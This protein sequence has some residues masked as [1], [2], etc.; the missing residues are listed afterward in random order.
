[1]QLDKFT[2]KSQEALQG[3]G[4]I[5]GTLGHQEIV[6]EHLFKIILEQKDGLL[7]PVIQKIGCD[8]SAVS[9][10]VEKL[11][12]KI[13]KVSGSGFGQVYASVRLTKILDQSLKE[14]D[15][16]RD[17]YVSLEHLVLAMLAEDNSAL[18]KMCAANSITRDAFL[19][20]L[21][22]IRGSQRVTDQNPEEKYQALEKYSANL[23]DLA[24]RGKLDPV[25]G[26]D[27]EVRRVIQVLSRRTKNNP[28]L[29][30][31]PGVGKTAIVE[32][33]A[34]RIVMGDI[35]ETL[36]NKEVVSLDLGALIAG[37]KYRG[38]FE[39][40][41]KAVLKEVKERQ[42]EIVLFIDEIHTLVGAGASEGAM[43]ASNMLKPALARGELHCVGATTLN[44]Y[45]TIEKDSALERRFQKV[46][47][48]EPSV[49]DSI[50][51]LRGI[52]E[53]YEVHHGVRIRDGATVAAVTL[54]KRYITDRFLP[55]KAIDLI[56]EAASHIRIE[57]DSM[58][59]E[60]DEV[61]RRRIK[62]EIEREALK[63]E[64]DEASKQRLAKL[65]A[66]LADLNEQLHAMKGHWQ[67]EHDVIQDIRKIKSDMEEAKIQEQ[68]AER[69]QDLSR[70]AE[71]RHGLLVELSHKLEE[72]NEKLVAIQADR[73]M[74]KEEV[75]AE[76]IAAVVAR[77]TGIPVDKLL[78]GE[79][80][81]LVGAEAQLAKRVIG[82]KRAISAVANAVRRARAGLQ[83]PNRPLGSFIFLGPTG[84]G[85]TELARALAEFLFDSEQAMVR[86]DM[87]E[88]MEKHS[89][90]RLIGAPP[91]YV[92]YEQGG[93]LTEAVRR[94][95][96]AVILFDE[97][98]KAHPDVFNVLL[99]ILDD[100]RMT[101]GQGRTVDFKN[102]ILIMTSNLG[103]QIIM[104]HGIDN[105]GR[106]ERELDDVLKQSFK[107]EFLNRVDDTITFHALT[108]VELSS[109]V[110]IQLEFLKSRMAA[111]GYSLELT[112]DAKEFIVDVG[113]DPL[114]GARPMKRAVQ[115]YLQDQLAM[116]ILAGH[117]VGKAT[118]V[119]DYK[120]GADALSFTVK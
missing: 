50:A 56:D 58:P 17:D 113:Y 5:A 120:R 48:L 83:D 92:G 82:Q 9:S 24:R 19:K 103:S 44:E 71:I 38:E 67:L 33:L 46:L 45:R 112:E 21:L 105:I 1:M 15:A 34:Q 78:E 77:W 29:I 49:E 75:G 54:S 96:Y 86:L 110:D 26:R 11:L 52:K 62:L 108:K 60:I 10:G 116:E 31:E 25:I 41:L 88:F 32:G 39:D 36:R 63:K 73:Q 81:R 104:E 95:P 109:I 66:E 40:R 18:A 64:K 57:I 23:T 69:V 8:L 4:H 79:K 35:P 72:Q 80:E 61:D 98:E 12:K 3:A 37:A 13:P 94:K 115:R 85:K 16:M 84:V 93:Y 97:I 90:A 70:V 59:T 14:A 100:G 117:F 6:P 55:D 89:V 106:M 118:I 107:P 111:Q 74:L 114:F 22:E 27:D 119:A 76:D 2:L 102:C 47:V 28:V 87:S 53:K 7:R 51:I 65:E 20:A 99:Q 91:G 42:G 101:D 43:D 30:G 68:Q